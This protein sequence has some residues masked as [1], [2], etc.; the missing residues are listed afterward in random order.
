MPRT[1]LLCRH[2]ER[3][4]IEAAVVSGEPYRR[5]ASRA[6]V[7]EAAVRRHRPHVAAAIVKAKDAEEKVSGDA[8]LRQIQDIQRRTL[9][10]LTKAEKADDAR[11]AL[12][13]IHQARENVALLSRLLG[14]LSSPTPTS[15]EWREVFSRYA[16]MTQEEI[17]E[18]LVAN[19]CPREVI[20]RFGRRVVIEHRTVAL[21]AEAAPV[22]APE[23][24][25]PV[26]APR[27]ITPRVI[28]V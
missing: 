23:D 18:D 6:G 25:A 16:Q 5:I 8:L 27:P 4:A 9:R 3:P 17:D 1:C 2:P 22:S 26:P 10:I 15:A 21:P 13:A 7:S 19:G 28:L 12:V 20:E 14:E 11:H 24:E